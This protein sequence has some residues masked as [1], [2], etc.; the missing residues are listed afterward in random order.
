[1]KKLLIKWNGVW[2]DE[3]DLQGFHVISEK[4]WNKFKELV[5]SF[6]YFNQWEFCVGTNEHVEFSSKEDF[7]DSFEIK[8]IDEL[9]ANKFAEIFELPF[10]FMPLV[11]M[12]E[13]IEL[14]DDQIE[15][16]EWLAE[17]I[18]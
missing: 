1:M 6:E 18:Y 13:S 16:L 15:E 14:T 12:Y 2:A 17:E 11:Q 3:M 8:E 4:A 10:G 5:S 7:F 9:L